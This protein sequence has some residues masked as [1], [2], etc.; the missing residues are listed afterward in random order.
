LH[1]SAF[2]TVP[3]FKHTGKYDAFWRSLL[4]RAEVRPLDL[5]IHVIPRKSPELPIGLIESPE[6]ATGLIES[7]K[8]PKGLIEPPESSTRH[9]ESASSTLLY[10]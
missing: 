5:C 3:M 10:A 6:P 8:S 4:E 9:I 7:P 2:V 1:A